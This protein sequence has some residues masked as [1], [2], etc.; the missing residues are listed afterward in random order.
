MVIKEKINEKMDACGCGIMAQAFSLIML[1]SKGMDA[2]V[3]RHGYC[4]ELPAMGAF[5]KSGSN[6]K[7]RLEK[8]IHQTNMLTGRRTS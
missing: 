6:F 7:Q 3:P 4:L 5:S 1:D 2:M 8:L